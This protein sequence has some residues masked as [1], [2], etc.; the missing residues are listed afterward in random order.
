MTDSQLSM[1]RPP[2]V[3]GLGD[4]APAVFK[5]DIFWVG[6]PKNGHHIFSE[7]NSKDK[8]H[9]I[10][11][12]RIPCPPHTRGGTRLNIVSPGGLMPFSNACQP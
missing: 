7:T 3:C 11:Q 5:L 8:G 2:S 9:H 1:A 4:I 12:G 6:D 10:F